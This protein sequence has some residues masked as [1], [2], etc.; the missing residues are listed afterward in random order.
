[1]KKLLCVVLSLILAVSSLGTIALAADDSGNTVGDFG[2]DL[3]GLITDKIKETDFQKALKDY[4]FDGS[5]L[6]EDYYGEDGQ[7]DIEA[8]IQSGT[9]QNV[10]MFGLSLDFL[11]HSTGALFWSTLPSSADPK[12]PSCKK[13]FPKESV[14]DNTCPDCGTTLKTENIRND[15][16][17]AKGNL[18]MMLLNIIKNH[19]SG[20]KLY[21]SEN[22]TR[23]CNFI[24]NLFFENYKNQTITFDIPLVEDDADTFYDTIAERSGL[25]ELIQNNWCNNRT[26]NYKPLL[27]TLG[28]KFSEFPIPDK[29]IYNAKIVSRFLLRAIITTTLNRGPVNY[30]LDVLWAFSRTYTLFMYEPIKALFNVKIASGRITEEELSTLKGLFNL[31][32]NNNDPTN[33]SKLQFVT[34]P[35]YR[36]ANSKDTVELFLYLMIYL[37]LVGKHASNPTA[38]SGIKDSINANAGLEQKEKDRLVKVVDGM[39][40]GNL[41]DLV[42]ELV[43]YMLENVSEAKTTMWETFVKFLK[44]F[45]NGFVK[46]IDRIYKN[47]KDIGNWGKGE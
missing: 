11:Y 33:T 46:I 9:A 2:F 35:V 6:P 29:D 42:P 44:N 17:V 1:M 4:N 14:P 26:L 32:A 41:N 47:F 10:Y 21:S 19:I 31:V 36:F 15:I 13:S 45:I 22:A 24:G 37:N 30:L 34:P 23:I 18:N 43:N 28:V 39:F 25:R 5:A 8:L 7:Y 38:V 16:A 27:Y 3:S 12:C 40:C 20:N